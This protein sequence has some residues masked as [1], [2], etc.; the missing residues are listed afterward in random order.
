M[1][2]IIILIAAILVASTVFGQQP[3][4][5]PNDPDVKVGK[6]ENG[7]TYYIRHNDKPAQRAE[8]YLATDVGAFQEEDDQDG[9]AHFLEHMCFNG[10]KN[11][12]EKKLLDWLQSIGAEFGRNINAS[13]GFEQTQYMLNNI[14][15]V[16][17]SIIDSCLLVLHDYS[18]FV[19]CDQE[20][21]DAER[22]V[23]LEERRTRRDAGW[24]MFEKSLPYYYGDTPYSRRTLIGGE[25][26]LKTFKRESLVNFY[27]KW[28]NPD[29]QAVIV[30]GDF[31]VDMMENKIKTIFSDIPA[32]A[33]PTE[34]VEYRLPVNKEPLVGIITDPEAQ[35]SSI[36]VLW[37]IDPLPKQFRNTDMA[38][39]NDLVKAYIRLIMSERFSDIASQP[40]APFL[41]ASFG[42][43]GLCNTSDAV[44]GNVSFK[45]GNA[46]PAFAAFMTE[47]EKMKRF[48]FTEGE[49]SRATENILSSYDKA[50]EAASTRKNADFVRP[51]LNN[52]YDNEPYMTPEME[53][54]VG[55]QYCAMLTA[56]L[57]SQFVAGII[58]EENLLILYNGP[59]KEGLV[60]PTE[61]E[62]ISILEAV[63]N[64]DIQANEE[65]NLNE[66]LI[67]EELKGSAVVKEKAGIHGSTVWTLANGLKVI[68]LPT[69]YKKDQVMFS[70][71]MDGGKNN[72]PLEDLASFEDNIWGLYLANTGVSKFSGTQLPKMLA[73]KR[74][75]AKP[76][77]GGYS[78][79]I[80]G[81]S[82][83]KDLETAFQLAY[84]YYTDP[85]FD[86][87]EYKV[88]MQQIDAVFPNIKNTPDYKFGVEL[89][90]VLYGNNPRVISLDDDVIAK[91]NLATI[92]KNYRRLFSG[93]DGATLL[94][95]GNVDIE[96]LKPMVEKYFGSLPEGKAL[97]INKKD[98]IQFAKGQT[99]QTLELEM[100][101][102]KSSVLQFYSAYMPINTRTNVTLSIAKYILD[103]RYTKNIREKE[104][105]TYGVG[106]AMVGHRSPQQRAL[107]QV[108]FDT[109]PEQAEK[110][111][112]IAK[113][114]LYAF[115][116]NGPTDEEL[117]MAVENLKKNLPESR[118]SNK[119]WMSVLE[120][121]DE[122]GI[123]YDKEYE[124]AINNV[125]SK[126]VKKILKK[127]LKQKN[128]IEFKSM[129][130]A[131]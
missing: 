60:N 83:P 30:V 107:I 9:L 4:A 91:A 49:V 43:G 45:D 16:R 119:Y 102:P 18:H 38:Y 115:A 95:I 47:L 17:E 101:T 6:L 24:R 64:A 78:H 87:N 105:G 32:P 80:T 116:Q 128:I 100:E 3:T 52:F 65:E 31:D 126:D 73:G 94:V 69:D 28:Y 77:I 110:L 35:S 82:A 40:D 129:P 124:D 2:R 106:V 13:T 122:H 51:L 21:I 8:F 39:M 55:K 34:K 121:W 118:I 70:L 27:R 1:K 85:R 5:L 10:T 112:G 89:D 62:L 19:N 72:I 46:V 86:E 61:S 12:P 42:V 67:S 59:E 93:V 90:K 127:I 14:P 33:V 54:M 68:A 37:K 7:L 84:L 109:N 29:M 22:G 99:N 98:I 88:G 71:D 92:E 120:K 76:Y 79:G 53:Q 123:D 108:Q 56:P 96:T 11:F 23:I 44:F 111:C 41:G 114:Q 131:K 36:E 75:S 15:I 66:P 25:E 104:G 58:P 130:L 113:E 97:K 48:G 50:V 103:M 26:Q 125:T 20:E 74:A 117:T 63:K 57:L 81:Q